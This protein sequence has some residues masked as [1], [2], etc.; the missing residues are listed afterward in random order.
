[1]LA[2]VAVSCV[3]NDLAQANIGPYF[4]VKAALERVIDT[5]HISSLYH[6]KN[7]QRNLQYSLESSNTFVHV[8]IYIT[9]STRIS[10]I[11]FYIMLNIGY[12]CKRPHRN[13]W[14]GSRSPLEISPDTNRDQT[15]HTA[16]YESLHKG[17]SSLALGWPCVRVPKH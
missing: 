14:G 11:M 16:T 9:Y 2:K 7:H 13:W 10:Y 15:S 8:Y 4:H 12:C 5:I 17:N 1:M 6:V 3:S